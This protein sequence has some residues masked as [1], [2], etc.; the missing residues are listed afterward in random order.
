M[1]ENGMAL[2]I[3]PTIL[4]F[5]AHLAPIDRRVTPAEKAAIY[6]WLTEDGIPT[7]SGRELAESLRGQQGTRSVYRLVA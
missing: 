4:S 6:G 1:M 3:T 2:E 5:A 7:R